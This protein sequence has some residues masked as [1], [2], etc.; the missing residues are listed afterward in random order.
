[1]RLNV[2]IYLIV[3]GA[4]FFAPSDTYAQRKKKNK[5]KQT[6]KS[7]E[8]ENKAE[9]LFIKGEGF[10]IQQNYSKAISL[11]EEALH[12]SPDNATIHY[13]ISEAYFYGGLF[14]KAIIHGKKAIELNNS[15]KEF[16]LLLADIYMNELKF[17]ESAAVYRTMLD[18]VSDVDQYYFDLAELYAEMARNEHSKKKLHTGRDSNGKLKE[19]EKKIAEYSNKAIDAYTR[20]EKH[21]GVHEE[22]TQ[23]KQRLYLGMNKMDEAINEGQ[24]LIDAF[25]QNMGYKLQKADLMYSNNR[26]NDAILFLL[27]VSKKNPDNPNVLLTLSDYYKG[28]GDEKKSKEML[29]KAFNNPLLDVDTKI[30][31]ISSYLQYASTPDQRQTALSLAKSTARAHP[32]KAQAHSIHADILYLLEQKEDARN[33]YYEAA[34]IDPTKYLIWQQIVVLDAELNHNE[35]LIK[36]ANEGALSHPD[37]PLLWLYSGLG[38]QL[39]KQDQ[40]AVKSYENGRMLSKGNPEMENQFNIQLGDAYNNIEAYT[41]SDSAFEAALEFDPNN[42]HVLNNYS[43]FLSLRNDRLEVAKA[44]SARVIRMHPNDPTFLDT[45]AWVLYMLKEYKEAKKYLATALKTSNDG[46]ILEHYGDAIYQLGQKDE[47]LEYWKKAKEAG[48]ATEN[49]DRKIRDKKLY[50]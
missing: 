8:K 20:A 18:N 2:F 36:H 37:K 47:A 23:K 26:Q 25:P 50:E 48:G 4:L 45:Y 34:K 5:K 31:M 46:T 32:T 11:Y 17:I 12:L 1:M 15:Q 30:K 39:T 29:N 22:L 21:Y 9:Y 24:L 10:F 7:S 16:Y 13:K 33:A 3:L 6:E 42:E 40:S 14:S 35:L 38:Y 27:S 19:I 28:I 44:M 41:K 43:Y 49:I